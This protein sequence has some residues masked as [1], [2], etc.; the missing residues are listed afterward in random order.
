M[1]DFQGFFGSAGGLRGKGTLPGTDNVSFFDSRSRCTEE[2][3]NMTSVF[4]EEVM[5]QLVLKKIKNEDAARKMTIIE[6]QVKLFYQNCIKRT[7]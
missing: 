2:A 1:I 4:K 7:A 6:N 5:R 3:D